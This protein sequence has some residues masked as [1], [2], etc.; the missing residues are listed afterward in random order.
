VELATPAHTHTYTHK[1]I[2]ALACKYIHTRKHTHTHTHT[3]IHT[4][5]DLRV[6]RH[7]TT[8]SSTASSQPGN[9]FDTFKLQFL[10]CSQS[11]GKICTCDLKASLNLVTTEL[12]NNS[13]FSL[14]LSH[15][16][17]HK[18]THTCTRLQFHRRHVIVDNDK[19]MN[20]YMCSHDSF[21]KSHIFVGLFSQN[22]PDI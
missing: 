18:H 15:T 7:T 4:V 10:Y 8:S 20:K 21:E 5:C 22:K 9:N 12:G 14:S 16:H 17:T 2:H 13:P 6:A 11:L 3:H 19:C 1:H